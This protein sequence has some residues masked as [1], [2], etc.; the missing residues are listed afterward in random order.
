MPD[1]PKITRETIAGQLATWEEAEPGFALLYVNSSSAGEVY[2]MGEGY[3][4]HCK[5]SDWRQ[6]EPTF[7]LAKAALLVSVTREM[8]RRG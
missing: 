7:A 4:W 1:E 6:L 2:P 5:L 8:L 3:R